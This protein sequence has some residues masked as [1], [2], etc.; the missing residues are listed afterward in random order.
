MNV[1]ESITLAPKTRMK[2]AVFNRL[3]RIRSNHPCSCV[4]VTRNC[5]T[6]SRQRRSERAENFAISA[7]DYSH[8][9][10]LVIWRIQR[11]GRFAIRAIAIRAIEYR[12]L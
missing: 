3:Q 9:F 11:A 6:L 5:A 4:D 7:I 2:E 10:E 1:S 12:R 8:G